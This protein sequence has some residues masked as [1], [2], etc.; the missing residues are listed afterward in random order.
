MGDL[1]RSLP[2]AANGAGAWALLESAWWPTTIWDVALRV[3]LA[4]PMTTERC[5]QVLATA[6]GDAAWLM[7]SIV[8]DAH[9][10]IAWRDDL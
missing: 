5:P 9:R 6:R 3:D 1:R 4:A 10:A 8:K 7:P 2:R